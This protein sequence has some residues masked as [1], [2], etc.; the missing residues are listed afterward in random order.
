MSR[1][2]KNL[3]NNKK[4]SSEIK[5]VSNLFP[6]LVG[7]IVGIFITSVIFFNHFDK[8]YSK[9]SALAIT[10]KDDRKKKNDNKTSNT[11]IV[12]DFPTI[13]KERQVTEIPKK[14]Y[15]EIEK[16]TNE[17]KSRTIYIFQVGSFK[18]FASADALKARLAFSGLS[19]YIEKKDI[20]GKGISFRVFVGPFEEKK[21]MDKVKSILSENGIGSVVSIEQ[22]IEN[23]PM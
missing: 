16:N 15:K 23:S 5:N 11:E 19:A 18:N 13:L 8:M 20:I 21:K 17:V 6:F 1:D 4:S 10:D 2:Y 3:R 7:L 9:K 22:K 14:E 12:F